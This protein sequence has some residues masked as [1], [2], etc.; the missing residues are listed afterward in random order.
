MAR[1][2][3]K[4]CRAA[5]RDAEKAEKAH[6][7]EQARRVGV[8]RKLAEAEQADEQA[9]GEALVAGRREPAAG[10]P[11]VQAELEQARRRVR[12]VKRQVSAAQANV[13][14]V[15]ASHGRAWFGDALRQVVSAKRAYAEAVSELER[16]RAR[17]SD[18][19]GFAAWAVSSGQA[20]GGPAN[21]ALAG[22]SGPEMLAF[23]RV[24]SELRADADWLEGWLAARDDPHAAPRLEL[25]HRAHP[26]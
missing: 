15:V 3:L 17:V 21:N 16:A 8:E 11:K 23:D 13:D 1:E 18:E 22:K 24:L 14:H 19:V 9:L 20:C 4:P 26:V 25:S 10:A 5:L 2:R 7:Q 12:A 6:A